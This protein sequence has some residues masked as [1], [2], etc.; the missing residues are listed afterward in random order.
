MGLYDFIGFLMVFGM[1]SVVF[2]ATRF[3]STACYLDRNLWYIMV[4]AY[5]WKDCI[6]IEWIKEN[7]IY[8]WSCVLIVTLVIAILGLIGS[9]SK[10]NYFNRPELVYFVSPLIWFSIFKCNRWFTK[11]LKMLKQQLT[12]VFHRL[13]G[14]FRCESSRFFYCSNYVTFT[15]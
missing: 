10:S 7:R 13:K 9:F 1:M 6:Y 11:K 12:V 14:G 3:V 5:A 4:R 8:Q 2:D 15:L